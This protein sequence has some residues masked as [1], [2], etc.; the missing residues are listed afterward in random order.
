IEVTVAMDLNQNV[1][2]S[3][4]RTAFGVGFDPV[5]AFVVLDG[6]G[7]AGKRRD[8]RQAEWIAQDDAKGLVGFEKTVVQ[9]RDAY[10]FARFSGGEGE[11]SGGGEEVHV[12]GRC[13]GFGGE[14]DGDRV[15][16]F[17]I[18]VDDDVHFGHANIF[19]RIATIRITGSAFE[20]EADI[21][22][23]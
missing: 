22:I 4:R 5:T 6:E 17:E 20:N 23:L 2:G 7:K 21:V 16:E 9:Q 10:G 11:G 15:C 1:T 3:L 13:A 19:G 12:G 8:L 14:I 18:T